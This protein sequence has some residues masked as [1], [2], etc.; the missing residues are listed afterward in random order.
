[1]DFSRFDSGR[2]DSGRFALGVG[3]RA[4]LVG[5]LSF[6]VVQM[7]VGRQLYA[8][9]LLLAGLA[10]LTVIDLARYA[11]KADRMISRFVAAL[12]A[13]EVEP[14]APR[15][16]GMSGMAQLREAMGRFDAELRRV[17]AGQQG[18]IEYLQTLTD[19]VTAALVVVEPDGRLGLINRAAQALATPTGL[20]PA[21]AA[22]IGALGPGG[23]AILRL[24]GG[25]RVLAAAARFTAAGEA[26]TLVSLQNIESELDAT[27]VKAWQDLARILAHEMMNSLTPIASLAQSLRPMLNHPPSANMGDVATAID[28]IGE[29]SARLISFVERYRQVADLP[30]PILRWVRLAEVIDGLSPL[31]AAGLA[32]QGARYVSRVEPADLRVRADPALLEQGLINLVRNGL[33]ASAGRPGAE[34]SLTAKL[35]GDQVVIS[36]ADNGRGVDPAVMERIFVPFFTTKA[37]GSGVGLSLVRQIALAHGGQIE[38]ARNSPEGMV[39]RWRL[40]AD[41]GEDGG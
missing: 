29:R 39:F 11:G 13:G 33:E 2:F 18:A 34:V 6:G 25:Q 5:A 32:A 27:E 15:E 4:L 40:P 9:A 12:A 41:A 7:L 19:T 17:R 31:L 1:M 24:P 22:Q 23:R 38:A 28:V 14:P 16:G 10:A 35:E 3:G 37:G 21:L 20:D 26:R 36:I 8:S 30:K